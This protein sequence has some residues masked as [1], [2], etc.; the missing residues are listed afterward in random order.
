[1][2][3]IGIDPGEKGAFAVYNTVTQSVTSFEFAKLTRK[4][5]ADTLQT[6]KI[7]DDIFCV[8]EKVHAAPGQGVVSMFTF[9]KNYGTWLGILT[10]IGIPFEEITP[11]VWQGVI[12]FRSARGATYNERKRALKQKAEQLHPEMKITLANADA[13]LICEYACRL[14]AARKNPL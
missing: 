9:G 11:Q 10:A 2:Y 13:V 7:L 5:I 3:I 12:G 4:D 8:I 6:Y 1:M 14:Y